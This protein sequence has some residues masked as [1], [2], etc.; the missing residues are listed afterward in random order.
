MPALLIEC[1]AIP[2]GGAR[3]FE[4]DVIVPDGALGLV[5][6]TAVAAARGRLV[7]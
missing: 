6:F 3:R 7:A 5:V 1:V 4:A 2:I